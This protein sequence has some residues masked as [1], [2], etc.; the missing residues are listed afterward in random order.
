MDL[1]RL[2]IEELKTQLNRFRYWL[3]YEFMVDE[4]DT[5]KFYAMERQIYEIRKRIE[6]LEESEKYKDAKKET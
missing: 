5:E 1:Q 2:S 6:K 4:I 3:N